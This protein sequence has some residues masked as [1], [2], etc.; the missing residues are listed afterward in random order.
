MI[1]RFI[2][3]ASGFTPFEREE[4][5][6][7]MVNQ[8]NRQGVRTRIITDDGTFRISLTGEDICVIAYEAAIRC[9][10]GQRSSDLRP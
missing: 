4:V 8:G 3:N 10:F 5:K 9:W 7:A 6:R 2:I 1:Q